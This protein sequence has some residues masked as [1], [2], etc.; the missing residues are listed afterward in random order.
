MDFWSSFHCD[1]SFY[2]LYFIS[3]AKLDQYFL[4]WGFQTWIG[5]AK[6]NGQHQQLCAYMKSEYLYAES[7]YQ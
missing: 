2:E 3:L 6:Y 1:K 5:G 4:G 7:L